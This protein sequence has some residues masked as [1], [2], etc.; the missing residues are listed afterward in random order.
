MNPIRLLALALAAGLAAAAAAALVPPPTAIPDRPVITYD[1]PTTPQTL[2]AAGAGTNVRV[3]QDSSGRD[4]NET[5]I[6]VSPI[7][8]GYLV[9]GAND[10]RSGSWGAGVY[11]SHDGGRTW[12]D[13]LMP[14]RKYPNQGDPTVAFCGDGI[15]VYAYLDYVGAYQPHRLI[16]AHSVDG[17]QS[18]VGPGVAYQGTTPFADKPYIACA[19]D[20]GS[21]YANRAYLSWTQIGFGTSPIVVAYSSDHG[22]TWNGRTPVSGNGGVQG[23]IPVAGR[24]GEVYVFWRGNGVIGFAHSLDG[25]ANFGAPGVVASITPIPDSTFRRNSFPTAAIDTSG[26]PYD[27][28]VYV[29][30]ADN[31]NGDPDIYFTRSTD[32]GNTW[33]PPRR[34][35]DDPVGN[36]R[37]QFF[38]WMSVDENGYVHLMWHDR[39]EDPDNR[40]YH[41]RIATSRDGGATFDRNLRV[42]DLASDGSLTGFLGD[43]AALAAGHGNLF[44]FWSDLRAGTGEEDVYVE[45]EPVFDY[46]IVSGVAFRPDRVTVDWDD[47]E[48]RT[49]SGV[50][51][52]VVTGMVSDLGSAD[53]AQRASCRYEDLPSPPAELPDLPPAGDALYVLIRAQGPRGDGSFGSGTDH[54]DPRDPFDDTPACL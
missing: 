36:G 44:P 42:T 3:N 35:N 54:P 33:D 39:R 24:D 13:G 37:D 18:W 45:R 11:V 25:G 30:W 50:V 16:S 14:F 27:G 15:P 10:A 7:D 29:A 26:G 20:D 9:G 5:T 6:A 48:P 38:P 28:T 51:Y 40:D 12:T 46:D 31:R 34:V 23:S 43:Y 2:E 41:I 53:A 22:Q 4:Q 32:G 52:D 17:G 49:G 1:P 21:P 47:Q 19:P 8:P